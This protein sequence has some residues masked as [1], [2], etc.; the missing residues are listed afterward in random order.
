MKG[1]SVRF[2]RASESH[3]TTDWTIRE[4]G[5]KGGLSRNPPDNHPQKT[6]ENQAIGGLGGLGGFHSMEKLPETREYTE[7][8][9]CVCEKGSMRNNFV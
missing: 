3:G 5:F 9:V 7:R 1:K 6:Q 8:G 4:V 2:E